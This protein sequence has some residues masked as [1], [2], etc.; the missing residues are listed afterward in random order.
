[1]DKS[2][3][4]G[5]G[6]NYDCTPDE[7]ASRAANPNSMGGHGQPA[8]RDTEDAQRRDSNHPQ[9]SGNHRPGIETAG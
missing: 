9:G 4:K 6:N 2:S 8:G 5:S 3:A 7:Y 1:M